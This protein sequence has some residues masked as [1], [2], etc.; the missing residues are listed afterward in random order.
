VRRGRIDDGRSIKLNGGDNDGRGETSDGQA[1]R[2]AAVVIVVKRA[3]MVRV[4][5]IQMVDVEVGGKIK[6]MMV[7]GV[8]VVKGVP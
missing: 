8:G 2:V 6:G 3:G 7:V 5:V 1:R 4:A